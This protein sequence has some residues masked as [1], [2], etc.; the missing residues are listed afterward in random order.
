MFNDVSF[1]S[2]GNVNCTIALQD[3]VSHFA[4]KLLMRYVTRTDYSAKMSETIFGTV[5]IE[6]TLIP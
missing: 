5:F 2:H 4:C 6:A 3:P 1:K